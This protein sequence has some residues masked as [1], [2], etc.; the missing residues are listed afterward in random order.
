MQGSLMLMNTLGEIVRS[1]QVND[2]DVMLKVQHLPFAV[3][4]LEL[5]GKEKSYFKSLGQA[6]ILGLT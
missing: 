1:M 4:Q 5:K 6:L 2:A 3:Y